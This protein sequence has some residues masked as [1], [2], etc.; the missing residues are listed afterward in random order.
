[1]CAELPDSELFPGALSQI[2]PGVMHL[3]VEQYVCVCVC[4]CLSLST[5][6]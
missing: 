3:Y 6:F 1:M 2:K 5:D 4:V